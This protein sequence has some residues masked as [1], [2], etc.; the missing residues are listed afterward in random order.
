ME[1]LFDNT[2]NNPNNP[3]HPPQIV[4]ERAGSMRTTDEMFQFIISALPYRSGDEDI[5]LDNVPRGTNVNL[6]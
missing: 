2:I 6:K 5:N 1:G 4:S 3:F